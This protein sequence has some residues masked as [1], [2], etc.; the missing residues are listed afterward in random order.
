M[1][2]LCGAS[3]TAKEPNLGKSTYLS[4][5]HSGERV[6]QFGA[7]LTMFFLMDPA[8]FF[9]YWTMMTIVAASPLVRNSGR[10]STVF[11]GFLVDFG[12]EGGDLA[13]NGGR[14]AHVVTG[15]DLGWVGAESTRRCCTCCG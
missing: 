12:D 5:A 3:N 10:S 14:V 15:S 9:I 2:K 1:I 13:R 11:P 7:G 6:V 8:F 4:T